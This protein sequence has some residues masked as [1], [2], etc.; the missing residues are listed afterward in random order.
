M[1][2]KIFEGTYGEN[3]IKKRRRSKSNNSYS[4]SY[5]LPNGKNNL[6]D[7]FDEQIRD[8]ANIHYD[9]K[10]NLKHSSEDIKKD[11]FALKLYKKY[12]VDKIDSK[13][14][15]INLIPIFVTIVYGIFDNIDIR[16]FMVL[17]QIAIGFTI[18][19]F[20]SH[21]EIKRLYEELSCVEY[22]ISII[23]NFREEMFDQNKKHVTDLGVDFRKIKNLSSE[24]TK[25]NDKNSSKKN[26]KNKKQ[27]RKN[28]S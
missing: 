7:M 9:I 6:V 10:N 15:Y 12:L 11:L 18:I 19:T 8:Y 1:L 16:G 25:V 20:L 21:G 13:E 22:A 27:K 2:K 3:L 24:K 4:L 23:E 28:K 17:V 26:N 5:S 14:N